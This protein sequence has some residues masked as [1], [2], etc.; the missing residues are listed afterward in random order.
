MRVT[1]TYPNIRQEGQDLITRNTPVTDISASSISGAMIDMVASEISAVHQ[2]LNNLDDKLDVTSASGQN[3]E[4]IGYL[5]GVTKGQSTVAMDLSKS[6]FHF[7]VDKRINKNFIQLFEEVYPRNTH[8]LIRKEL[9]D[10]G[11]IDNEINVN[12]ITL[13]SGIILT[14]SYGSAEY[15]TTEPVEITSTTNEAYVPVVSNV[16]GSYAN[17]ESNVLTRHSLISDELIKAMARYIFCTNTY[18]ISNGRFSMTDEEYR[19]A[20]S[21]KTVNY[22]NNEPAVRQAALSVP[23]VRNV[24]FER[25][26]YGYGTFGLMVEG[27]SPIVS[28]A[29]QEVVEQSVQAVAG[30]DKVF[31][32][33]PKYV[34][35]SI[36][37]D[38]ICKLGFD[39]NEIVNSIKE[40]I[41]SYIV[42]LPIGET[43]IWNQI[44][45]IVMSQEGVYDFKIVYFKIGDYDEVDKKIINTMIVRTVNQRSNYNEKFYTDLNLITVCNHTEV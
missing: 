34:G 40:N 8:M 32:T 10:K 30:G 43:I 5:V 28:K 16:S 12:K 36:K 38:V 25:G 13:P 45:N 42:N 26:K 11:Y 3:L 2:E 19:Y 21:L 39:N 6:N 15:R 14:N 23:G 27:V 31:V 41:T 44:E 33:V 1:R 9:K 20:I 24:T 35:V 29:L 22:I 17:I 7:Y 18:P 4:S 37:L